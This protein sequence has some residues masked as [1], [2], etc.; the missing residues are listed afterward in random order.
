MA[1]AK[2]KTVL[3]SADRA[4]ST[5]SKVSTRS[6]ADYEQ[7]D[8]SIDVISVYADE[9]WG[10]QWLGALVPHVCALRGC[11]QV[12]RRKKRPRPSMFPTK[13]TNTGRVANNSRVSTRF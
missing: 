1:C 6:P 2:T 4:L 13:P 12:T 3:Y 9:I 11:R 10:C 8:R 7:C 5:Y